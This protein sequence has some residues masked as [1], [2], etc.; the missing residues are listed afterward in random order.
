MKNTY[1]FLAA[2]LLFLAP[3]K[4]SAEVT[5]NYAGKGGNISIRLHISAPV[6][7]AFI[8]QQPLPN[9]VRLQSANPPPSGYD[10]AS[11]MVKWF[12]KHPGSGSITLYIQLV[13]PM[14]GAGLSGGEIRYRLPGNGKMVSRSIR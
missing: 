11:S 10:P 14:P 1:A 5:G 12:F 7:T 9:G 4:A 6:P 2:A 13:G 8:V 3:F